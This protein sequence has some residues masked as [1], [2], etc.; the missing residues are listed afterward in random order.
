VR[1]AVDAQRADVATEPSSS[2]SRERR[3][4]ALIRA[5]SSRAE[6]GLTT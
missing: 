1:G 2:S 4:T 3:S 6:K 5:S